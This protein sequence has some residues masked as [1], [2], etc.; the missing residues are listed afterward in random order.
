MVWRWDVRSRAAH[1]KEVMEY[2]QKILDIL[3]TRPL[4]NPEQPY[5]VVHHVRDMLVPPA[6]RNE[7]ASVW[8]AAVEFIEEKESRVHDFIF[9]SGSFV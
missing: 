5:L 1:K 9:R 7:K 2:V 4:E 3:Q 8:E 6:M